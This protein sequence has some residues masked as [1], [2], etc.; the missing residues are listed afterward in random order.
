M[1]P[2]KRIPHS[3]RVTSADLRK[4]SMDLSLL[5]RIPAD[6]ITM[7]GKRDYDEVAVDLPMCSIASPTV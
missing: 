6:S 3:N 1:A 2:K 5:E 4:F 7:L